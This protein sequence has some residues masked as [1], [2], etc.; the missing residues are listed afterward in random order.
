MRSDDLKTDHLRPH[1]QL[2]ARAVLS[3]L[4]KDATGGGCTAFYSP[5]KWKQRGERF[6][7]NSLLVIV[8]DGGDLAPFCNLDYCNH[9]CVERLAARL[10]KLGLF[11]EQ[12]T[13]WYSAVYLA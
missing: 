9:R 8:H 2:I 12:C 5:D 13:S 7:T 4:P 11:V 6:G 1:E 3:V 10:Q